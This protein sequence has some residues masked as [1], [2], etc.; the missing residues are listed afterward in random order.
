M[1]IIS[2]KTLGRASAL[3]AALTLL[4][5]L[6][7]CSVFD[8]FFGGD[9]TAA[10]VSTEGPSD[11]STPEPGADTT[12]PGQSSDTLPPVTLPPDTTGGFISVTDPPVIHYYPDPLTGLKV[13]FDASRVRPVAISVDNISA[14][15]PQS[16]IALADIV[17]ECMVENGISRLI[18]ITNKYEGNTEVF[19]PVRSVRDYMVSLSAA[20][21]T[22]LVGAGYSPTGYTSITEN[23]IDYIDGVHDRYAMS[24]FFRDP[25]RYEK[26]GYEH[27]LMI[28]GQGIRALAA[29]NNYSLAANVREVFRFSDS[30][31]I[32]GSDATHAVLTYSSYQ[33]VQLIYSR[34]ENAY[35]RYQYG[36]KAHID[37]ASGEQLSFTNVFIL[38]ADSAPI[39]G[40]TEGRITVEVTGTGSGYYLCGGKYI[41]ITWTRAG[42]SS[43]FSFTSD[44]GSFGVAA[45]KTFIAVV[46]SKLKDTSSIVLNYKMN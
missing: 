22:L 8:R 43:P 46:D 20:F 40:D 5:L 10:P 3:L 1:M 41:P 42:F 11:E 7:G 21:G 23:A 4:I 12:E 25:A 19:G 34:K 36:T 31:A 39:E 16:G 27:S 13:T 33:Q 35:Y 2:R 29:H 30:A 18:L 32:A 6:S 37:A 14:A 44:S 24:G 9:T 38:F 28:T 26:S 45:G 17:I 15:T